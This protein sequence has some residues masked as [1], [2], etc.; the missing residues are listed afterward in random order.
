[1]SWICSTY[2][3]SVFPNRRNRDCFPGI[4]LLLKCV[5]VCVALRNGLQGPHQHVLWHAGV[6]STWGFDRNVVHSRCGLVGAGRP[7]LWDAGWGGQ[8]S[9]NHLWSMEQ[10]SSHL[11]QSHAVISADSCHVVLT[12]RFG[13]SFFPLSRPSPATTRRRCLTASSTMKSATHDSSRPRPSPSWEGCVLVI[14]RR[15]SWSKVVQ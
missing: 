2:Q 9:F 5:C 13:S 14:W 1:M 12:F 6:S 7:H 8:C 3:I 4:G 10:S 11:A 15:K